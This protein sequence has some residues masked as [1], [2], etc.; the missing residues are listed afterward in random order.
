MLGK[1]PVPLQVFAQKPYDIGLRGFL[2]N[3]LQIELVQNFEY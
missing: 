1:V 2:Q 3:F